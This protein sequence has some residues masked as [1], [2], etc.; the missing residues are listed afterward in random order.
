MWA[1]IA[2]CFP[3]GWDASSP[4]AS[5][6]TA[7]HQAVSGMNVS[8][9]ETF[10]AVLLFLF[11]PG[12]PGRPPDPGL[13]STTSL[14]PSSISVTITRRDEGRGSVCPAWGVCVCVRSHPCPAVKLARFL[15]RAGPVGGV[16][17]IG[18]TLFMAHLPRFFAHAIP[19]TPMNSCST[20]AS[21]GGQPGG[22]SIGTRRGRQT[23]VGFFLI[24]WRLPLAHG[25][26]TVVQSGS[27]PLFHLAPPSSSAWYFHAYTRAPVAGHVIATWAGTTTLEPNPRYD[28]T[29]G[30]RG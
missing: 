25:S 26:L 22:L 23:L 12:P 28:T 27:L 15:S 16:S 11:L 8:M 19:T 1:T 10:R 30:R 18:A 2:V 24:P 29:L 5:T 4:V 9:G 7:T 17:L 14:V 13:G 20:R 21:C 3:G 6:T